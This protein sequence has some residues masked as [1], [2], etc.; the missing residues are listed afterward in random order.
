M[1]FRSQRYIIFSCLSEST[2]SPLYSSQLPF[3]PLLEDTR[4]S[5]CKKKNSFCESTLN[6][7]DFSA[8]FC[9]KTHCIDILAMFDNMME[10]FGEGNA[11]M[12]F[13]YVE[14]ANLPC[15]S[16]QQPNVCLLWCR[17]FI[18]HLMQTFQHSFRKLFFSGKFLDETETL[19][20]FEKNWFQAQRSARWDPKP[21]IAEVGCSNYVKLFWVR[22]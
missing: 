10:C 11:F 13:E 1:L 22:S 21:V 8:W 5:V 15:S 2:L 7:G 6:S 12:N 3:T 19:F 4:A 14:V 17:L 9:E 18:E 20:E 16:A